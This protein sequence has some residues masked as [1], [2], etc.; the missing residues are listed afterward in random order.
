VDVTGSVTVSNDG[1]LFFGD[2][3][4]YISGSGAADRLKFITNGSE[5]VRIDSSQRVGIGTSSPDHNLTLQ[6]NTNPIFE[7]VQVAGGPY[8][9]QIAVGGNDLQLRAS[10]GALIMYTGNADGASSTERMRITSGGSVGIG[11]SSPT[12]KLHIKAT[13]DS[14]NDALRIE[15]SINSHYYTLSSDAGNGSFRITKSGTERLRIDSSG[16]AKFSS[17]NNVGRI[18]TNGTVT[19]A[20]DSSITLTNATAG[21]VIAMIYDTSSG[22]G[23][24]VFFSYEGSPEI[25]KQSGSNFTIGDTDN[26][27]CIIKSANNHTATFKN[28]IGSSRNFNIFLIGGDVRP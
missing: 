8:K 27:Y 17:A 26:K 14:V 5:A 2:T 20:D 21:A 9:H 23:A 4:T 13:S 3:S 22:T 10:S 18:M 6:A 25:I 1:A 19:I 7:M 11:T 24:S 15:S 28:R 16:I 12:G